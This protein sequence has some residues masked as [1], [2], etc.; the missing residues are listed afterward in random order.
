MNPEAKLELLG[1]QARYDL[2]CA[3]GL[4]PARRR[5]ETGR[6]IYPTAMPDGSRKRTLK[7]LLDNACHNDCGYCAQRAGRDTRRTRLTPEELAR[8]FDQLVRARKV[9][10]LF[11]SSGLGGNA[12]RTMDRMIAA[13][14]LIRSRC[15]WRGFIHLKILPGAQH[16][17]V[18]R[19]AR[20]AQR[21]S[22]NLEAPGARRLAM[23][24][25]EKDFQT[26]I[27]ERMW[28]I[29]NLVSDRR[30]LAKGHTTQF[31]VGA[32]GE[33]DAEIV[34]ASARLY[35]DYRI[36]RVYYSK[37]QP[38]AHTPLEHLPPVSFMRE[39]R[40]Y[41]V[42]FLLRKYGFDR[43]EIP[44]EEDGNLSLDDD[45]KTGWARRHPEVFPL[46]VNKAGRENLLRV[47]GLGP[48]TVDRILAARSQGTIRWL[49]DL[50]KLGVVSRRAAAYLLFDGHAGTRQLSLVS[51]ID[52]H[53]I[54]RYTTTV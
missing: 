28:W 2:S 31:V 53:A 45:P 34:K 38:V 21:I 16:A 6:W 29:K 36:S 47:P 32:S 15:A 12:V 22:I 19:A 41:Q 1:E 3:C 51:T 20:L 5:A 11:L 8:L 25:K 4:D 42:D 46:E 33:T 35:D 54:S 52:A 18:E 39:H 48:V 13:V 30:T 9:E 44:F 26:G 7:V 40:L 10:A 49:D 23:L 24:S 43:D 37:F 27:L 50:D 17:Q 14:E